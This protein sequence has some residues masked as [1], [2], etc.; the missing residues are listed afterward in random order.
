MRPATSSSVRGT[1]RLGLLI[2]IA[3]PVM[4]V[5]FTVI[6]FIIRK[7]KVYVGVTL[8]VLSVLLF[9]FVGGGR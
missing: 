5:A 2:L 9:S 8:I 7:V 1:I 3:T 4:K 6:S